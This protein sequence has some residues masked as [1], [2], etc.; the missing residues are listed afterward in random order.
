MP[1]TDTQ[2]NELRNVVH[3]CRELLLQ[4]VSD[5]LRADH[6]IHPDGKI[7]DAKALPNLSRQEKRYR[8]R[9]VMHLRHRRAVLAEKDE[10]KAGR[11]AVELLARE[12]AFT[13]LNRLCAFKM[14]AA[15]KLLRDPV[16]KG[17]DSPGFVFYCAQQLGLEALPTGVEKDRLYRE[18]LDWQ[19]GQLAQEMHALFDPDDAVS[20]LYPPQRTLDA[21]LDQLNRSDLAPIWEDDETIGW[22]YQFFTPRDLVDRLR[23]ESTAPRDSYELGVRNQFFTRRYVVEFLIDNTL[24]RLWWEMRGGDTKLA[25]Q[26]RYLATT[27]AP[28]KR[29]KK[30]PREIR[31]IDPACGSG[32]FLLYAFDLLLVI[33]KEAYDDP[34]LGP[35]LQAEFAD[36]ETFLCKIPALILE[37]NLHGVDI[38]RR[39]TQI[40]ALAL[41][42]RA[43][44][45]WNAMGLKGKDRPTI[46]RTNIVC[47]ES[48]P[49]DAD[50]LEEFVKTLEYPAIGQFVRRVFEKM[51]LAGVAGSLLKIESDLREDI[52]EARRQWQRRGTRA[53]QTGLDLGDPS[54]KKPVA[55]QETFDLDT[56]TDESFFHDAEKMTLDALDRYA[57]AMTASAD[58]DADALSLY[59]R[60]FAEDTA[61]GF[62]FVNLCQ[63][64]YDVVLMN[65]PFGDAALPSKPYLD[66]TYGDTKGD[67]YKAFVECFQDRLVSGGYLGIISSRTGFF[68]GQSADW[69]ERIVL[70]LYRPLLLADLGAGVLDA[71]VETAAYVLRNLTDEERE[72][73]TLSLLADLENVPTDRQGKF[74][75]NQYA[76]T[77]GGLKR[78]QAEQE[79]GWLIVAGFVAHFL[80]EVNLQTG[81]RSPDKYSVNGEAVRDALAGSG[82]SYSLGHTPLLCLRLLVEP[83]NAAK[84]T[85]MREVLGNLQDKRRFPVDPEDFGRVPGY[86]FSYWV[87]NR[88]RDLFQRYPRFDCDSRTAKR[89]P[90]SGDDFWRV[91]A[92]W[93]IGEPASWP[94]SVRWV[95]FAKGGSFSPYHGSIPVVVGWDVERNTFIGY[96]GRPGRAD[97]RPEALEF[98]FQPGLTWP[99]RA[100]R[101]GP[102]A[103]PSGGVFS[104]RGHAI[105]AEPDSIAALLGFCCSLPFDF[106]LKMMLGRFGYPE[107]QSG[108]IQRAPVPA[109]SGEDGA[110]LGSLAHACMNLKRDL[111][112]ANE[113]SH[114]F[115]RPASSLTDGLTL[116]ERAAAWARHLANIEVKL[117]DN[118]RQIDHI[119]FKLYGIDG[120][121]RKAIEESVSASGETTESNADQDGDEEEAG[122]TTPAADLR[123]LASDLLSYCVG[124][125]FGRFDVRLGTG[126]RT[127]DPLPDPF[128]PL[129]V[130]SPGMLTGDDGLPVKAAPPGYPLSIDGDGILVDDADENGQ[131]QHPDELVTRVRTVLALLFGDDKADAIEREACAAMGI[132]SLRDY[133]RRPGAGGFWQDH[134]RRYS[135]SR[136]KAPIYWLLQSSRKSYALWLYYHT[137]DADILFK[138]RINYAEPKLAREQENLNALRTQRQTLG[139]SGREARQMERRID[140]QEALVAEL[141]DFVQAL[142]RAAD[143]R[144]VPDLNDGVV[145]TIAPLRELVPWVE[146]KRYW[147]ELMQ[148]KYPWASIAKQLRVKGIVNEGGAT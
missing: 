96:Y 71:M 67:I 34:D 40:A 138:A 52:A 132:D 85:A 111:Q 126:E 14:M 11:I 76:T 133:F 141:T 120:E 98:F 36:R 148:G 136:R 142:T 92:W 77:R 137:L 145:L 58:E 114:L 5:R 70:R 130:C 1:L 22:V 109:L 91:R 9:L 69:R 62:A 129:P 38:D 103:W 25:S 78:H 68:L 3:R 45:V 55:I 93:E 110:R 118:Q 143:L 72:A 30:D 63:Q 146:A 41:Y 47:A 135:K 27:E 80:G 113:T 43:Q 19:A 54:L 124:C 90:T 49:G 31:V 33:Y 95:T 28:L 8:E 66:A 79:L 147:E 20:G 89:G 99:L 112:T 144:L 94:Q 104:T 23:K 6:G 108:V 84:E 17:T 128:A 131:A 115:Q 73:L 117:T 97:E 64:H 61:Q 42:L 75:R 106:V 4:A 50:R 100:A 86:P 29:A 140:K 12:I 10:K 15:R 122:N 123:S 139:E 107:Y 121:D 13:H 35:A 51:Q 65:P 18:Y 119:A 60:L 125:A 39:A 101:F 46:R 2:R 26:C 102:Y 37:H 105:I 21:V 7:E 57:R 83:D 24:G 48:M 32:H 56:V 82:A 87:S 16:G 88:V 59:R 53:V 44:R 74:S 134:I 116:A 81:R 127:P